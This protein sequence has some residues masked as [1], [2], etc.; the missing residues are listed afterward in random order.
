MALHAWGAP[1]DPTV[2]GL[3]DV[4][5]TEALAFVR[6]LR[7]KSGERI[8]LTH[9]VGHAVA[10][11]IA[12]QP[13]VNAIVRFGRLYQR[14]T[15]DVF[16]Q[17]AFGGGGNL[18]GHKVERADQKGVAAIARELGEGA[19]KVRDGRAEN[20]KTTKRFTHMPAPMMGLALRAASLLT[21][22]LGLDLSAYG[23]PFDSFGSAMVTNVGSFGLT[24]G[25]PPLLPISRCP[26]VVLVGEVQ[27]RPV[28]RDGAVVV[29][30]VLPIG[31]TFDHRLLDGFHAGVLAKEFRRVLENPREVLAEELA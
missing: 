10:R 9:L 8:T 6:E 16:F 23:V 29:R 25:L 18:A 31:V 4:D 7:A 14:D 27:D 21:Y 17:V 11:A 13:D 12:Q 22:D 2:H 5:A 20:V 15:I 24:V 28:A 26:L 30:P 19:S 1:S 3:L